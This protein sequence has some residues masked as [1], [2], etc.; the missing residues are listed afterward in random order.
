MEYIKA[1][2]AAAD[3]PQEQPHAESDEEKPLQ[4]HHSRGSHGILSESGTLWGV[5]EDGKDTLSDGDDDDYGHLRTEPRRIELT[6][7]GSLCPTVRLPAMTVSSHRL[8][9]LCCSAFY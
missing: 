2:Y 4:E 7:P 1:K 8:Y 5:D 6:Y 3:A 9:R